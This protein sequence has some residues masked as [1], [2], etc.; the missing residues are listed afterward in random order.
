MKRFIAALSIVALL[1]VGVAWAVT[2]QY[3]SIRFWK[4]FYTDTITERTSAAGVT[5]SGLLGTVET[6]TVGA[7]NTITAAECGTTFFLS[8]ATEFASTLPA[9]STVSAGCTFTFIVAAAPASA[10]WSST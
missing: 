9:I 8:H 5:V 1:A 3:D 2:D 7:T 10:E 6:E 4:G